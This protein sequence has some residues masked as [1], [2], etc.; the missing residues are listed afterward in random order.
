VHCC[1]D[2]ASEHT[3]VDLAHERPGAGLAE[4]LVDEAVAARFY[5]DKLARYTIFCQ[6]ALDGLCLN[7]CEL[8][9]S[10][11]DTQYVDHSLFVVRSYHC[12]LV[13]WGV[14][15]KAVK[16]LERVCARADGV[17]QIFV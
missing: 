16:P 11:A 15:V 6:H 3:I 12:G 4:G 9:A 7:Q 8:A 5:D 1:V 10:G 14:D 17:F 13:P 2:V